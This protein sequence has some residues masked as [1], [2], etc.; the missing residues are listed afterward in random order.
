MTN[1]KPAR[2]IR[3]IVTNRDVVMKTGGG[4]YVCGAASSGARSED[5]WSGPVGS[6]AVR[7]GRSGELLYTGRRVR[8]GGPLASCGRLSWLSAH[9]TSH[10]THPTQHLLPHRAGRAA[11]I[12]A[13]QSCNPLLWS[14]GEILFQ[15]KRRFFSVW[16]LFY[17]Y[18]IVR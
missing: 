3:L 18:V 5:W 9:S 12:T 14:T 15:W 6:V 11:V 13:T 4:G 7:A 17:Y 2:Q 8:A 16:M 10:T 1:R